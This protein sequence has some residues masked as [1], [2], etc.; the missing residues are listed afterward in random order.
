MTLKDSWDTWGD[1]ALTSRASECIWMAFAYS[2]TYSEIATT[3]T[4]IRIRSSAVLLLR[5]EFLKQY[6][7]LLLFYATSLMFAFL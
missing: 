5:K 2:N 1:H 6:S 3:T 7:F 4:T